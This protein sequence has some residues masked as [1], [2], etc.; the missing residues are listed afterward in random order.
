MS[1]MPST[2]QSIISQYEC[3]KSRHRAVRDRHP[4]DLSLRLHRA[5]SWLQRAEIAERVEPQD[6]DGVF[7]FYWIAFNAAYA[8]ETL[9]S[10]DTNERS[11]FHDYFDGILNL[12]NN[13][14][15]FN[16]I[17]QEFAGPIRLFLNNHYV[18]QPFWKHQNGVAG[19]E[20]WERRFD[21]SKELA[22]KA[23]GNM[24]THTVL[25]ILF[26]RLY[27]LRNQLVHGGATWKGSVN[28][29]QVEDGARIMAFLVPVFIQLMMDN[30]N[31]DWG[32]P[33][34]PVVD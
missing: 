28:R 15:I 21:A 30:P 13:N 31:Q 12:D 27:V 19:Y 2:K 10:S 3:L 8:E 18:F 34:Y 7:I 20:D 26:D 4:Q 5:L 1:M 33:Y 6:P 16:A 22:N 14:A 9:E 11:A 17:W 24:D 25:T 32:K 29:R 23:L